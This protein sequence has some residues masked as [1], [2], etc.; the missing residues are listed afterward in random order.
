MWVF[1]AWKE[2]GAQYC[3]Q[4]RRLL[5][6]TQALADR[7]SRAL[8][9]EKRPDFGKPLWVDPSHH[10]IPGWLYLKRS[11]PWGRSFISAGYLGYE[12]MFPSGL[13]KCSTSLSGSG[14]CFT[15]LILLSL[16]VDRSARPEPSAEMIRLTGGARQD[17]FIF[18]FRRSCWVL[19]DLSSFSFVMLC[20]YFLFLK[21]ELY[22]ESVLSM[23]LT[24]GN[25]R[26]SLSN[27]WPHALH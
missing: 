6:V 16:K 2:T 19:A 9:A 12:L 18:A 25:L 20:A 7:Q 10:R 21:F 17:I 27:K 26:E 14:Y 13:Q 15:F 8:G 3:P 1:R 24:F 11:G 23:R 4:I 5:N 22:F